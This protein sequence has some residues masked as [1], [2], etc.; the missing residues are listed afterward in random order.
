MLEVKNLNLTIEMKTILSNISFLLKENKITVLI[1]KNG[2][3]KSS[4][5][6]SINGITKYTGNII[7]NNQ[8]ILELK[9]NER[10]K[11][12]A[13]LPQYLEVVHITVKDLVSL[14]RNPYLKLFSKLSEK[15]RKIINDAITLFDLNELENNY[16]D[17]L[18]GGELQKAY[19]AMLIAQD[20]NILV[21]DEPTTYLDIDFEG[22]FLDKIKQLKGNKTILLVLHNIT[23]AIEIADEV[24]IL[25]NGKI[26]YNDSKDKLLNTTIIEELF[27]VKKYIIKDKVFYTK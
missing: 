15:D 13:I 7:L 4:I 14:G 11:E 25:D 16:L 9:N 22:Y 23:K 5:V 17:T 24:I 1:G 3:G 27:N 2:S 6:K 12:I 8:N 26:I 19:L 20:T 10:A 18:S 21:L